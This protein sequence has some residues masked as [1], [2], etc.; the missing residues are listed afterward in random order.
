MILF[1]TNRMINTEIEANPVVL[2]PNKIG[3]IIGDGIYCGEVLQNN[4]ISL[5]PRG[6]EKSLFDSVSNSE[7]KK[8]WVF[9]VHGNNQN[10]LKNIKKCRA[11]EEF[12]GVNVV[13]FSWP[14]QPYMEADKLTKLMKKYTKQ[15]LLRLIKLPASS[16]D[17]PK[18]AALLLK[19]YY[20]NYKMAKENA[21]DSA[22][23]LN[24]AFSVVKKMLFSK[25]GSNA[26]K[27]LLI[28][29]LGH[30]VMQTF[31]Q[32]DFVLSAKFN[33][34]ILH[35]ADV[36]SDEHHDWIPKLRT[37]C[38]GLYITTNTYDS[39]L[40][41]SSIVNMEERL[42]QTTVHRLDRPYKY[43]DFT[44]GAWVDNNHNFFIYNKDDMNETI[45]KLMNR[46]LKGNKDN[47]P[48]KPFSSNNSG[49]SLLSKS[50]LI[51]RLQYV[52]DPTGDGDP[53]DEDQYIESL[54]GI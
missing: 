15:A 17:L 5:Y 29:S 24:D 44:D 4:N 52:M 19:D 49:F 22:N 1:I 25:F 45:F 10:V 38:D 28:H 12:H 37:K 41:T 7:L 2:A 53:H 13:A 48:T 34:I 40:G 35:Q 27:S 39:I 54:K 3:K 31:V 30:L 33:N 14:S 23:D 6:S 46:L 42:G 16:A 47:L 9:F 51:Y 36:D 8:P 21:I 50:R 11:M 18:D 20:V 43:L 26:K 32:E